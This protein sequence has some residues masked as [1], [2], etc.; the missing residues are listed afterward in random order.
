MP[1]A[2]PSKPGRFARANAAIDEGR[3]DKAAQPEE[4]S[5]WKNRIGFPSK[6]KKATQDDGD[7]SAIYNPVNKD[8]RT[9][10]DRKQAS[11]AQEEKAQAAKAEEARFD[12]GALAPEGL[13]K[14]VTPEEIA[15]LA[16]AAAQ[17]GSKLGES[18][19][20]DSVPEQVVAATPEV[21]AVEAQTASAHSVETQSVEARSAEAKTESESEEKLE[22]KAE[23]P[24]VVEAPKESPAATF[25]A[26]KSEEPVEAATAKPFESGK[27]GGVSVPTATEM[28]AA[29]AGL[30]PEAGKSTRLKFRK[31]IRIARYLRNIIRSGMRHSIMSRQTSQ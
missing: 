21:K 10:I 24:P 26:Q 20:A 25:A 17:V 23:V 12:L 13:P 15:A 27:E 31:R 22:A 18:A 1:R 30:V 3:Y 19:F 5:G 6:N 8:L 2:E 9:V 4:D 16:A 28:M 7:D 14:D 29:I 11:D